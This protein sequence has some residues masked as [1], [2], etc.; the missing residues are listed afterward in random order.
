MSRRTRPLL[1]LIGAGA[2]LAVAAAGMQP[3]AA[4]PGKAPK[5]PPAKPTKVVIIVVDS[6]SKEIV[7]KYGMTNVQGLMADYVDTPEELPRAHRVGHRG[8]PQ[9]DHLRPAAQAHGVDE[10]GLPRRR[11]RAD[12]PRPAT[13]SGL[14][15]TSDMSTDLTTLQKH[16]GYKKLD[17][18]LDAA[19]PGSKQ[20]T[21][22]P[23]GYAGYAFGSAASDSI[24]TFSSGTC[25]GVSGQWRRPGGV[26]P[27]AW[28]DD[29]GRLH[30]PVLGAQRLPDVRLRHHPAAGAPVPAGQRPLRDRP[31]RRARGRRR[32]GG[33]R[34]DQA[35]WTTSRA[36][37]A[38]S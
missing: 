14:Y 27:P 1:A 38:S 30:E 2:A 11:R 22:S 19:A 8:H 24:I 31:R 18:Y 13:T 3:G 25:N 23:K 7:D 15:I 16:A 12:R 20:F 9:R 5:G 21:I 34:G 32:V 10:R 35:S 37:T 26:N 17:A 36:G 6:L 29:S 28:L 4:A 33:R